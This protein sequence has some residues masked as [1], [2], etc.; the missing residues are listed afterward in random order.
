MKTRKKIPRIKRRNKRKKE[1][2]IMEKGKAKERRRTW[3]GKQR[4]RK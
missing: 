4:E 3:N 1:L 2:T